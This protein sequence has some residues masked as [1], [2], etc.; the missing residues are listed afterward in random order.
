MPRALSLEDELN[1]YAGSQVGM[2]EADDSVLALPIHD[3]TC[4]EDPDAVD[5]TAPHDPTCRPLDA[6]WTGSGDNLYF[7]IPYWISFKLDAA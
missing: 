7:R 4:S 5:P 6:K 3:K 2:A 1:S